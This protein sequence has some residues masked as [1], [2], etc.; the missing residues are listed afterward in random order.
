MRPHAEMPLRSIRKDAAEEILSSVSNPGRIVS[1]LRHISVGTKS[2]GNFTSTSTRSI[3]LTVPLD[4]ATQP[5]AKIDDRAV[6]EE[7]P[8]HSNVCQRV[9]NI[10]CALRHIN[11]FPLV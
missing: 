4:R 10:P 5:L 11:W 9:A 6:T 8:S 7:I 2:H 3:A 1:A